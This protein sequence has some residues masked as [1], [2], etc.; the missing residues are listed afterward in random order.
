M[1]V[2][3]RSLEHHH[4]LNI[5]RTT[6][7]ISK[8]HNSLGN[9]RD[10]ILPESWV[11]V[12]RNLAIINDLFYEI[13]GTPRRRHEGERETRER[14]YIHRFFGFVKREAVWGSRLIGARESLSHSHA[15]FDIHLVG[16][17]SYGVGRKGDKGQVAHHHLLH[18]HT[19]CSVRV[20]HAST[21]PAHSSTLRPQ[22]LPHQRHSF[23][24]RNFITH[25]YIGNRVVQPSATHFLQVLTIGTRAHHHLR[26]RWKTCLNGGNHL[27]INLPLRSN[28]FAHLGSKH[29]S[30]LALD[31]LGVEIISRCRIR[32][33][34][35]LGSCHHGA[36]RQSAPGRRR[37]VAASLLFYE[38]KN[39]ARG[40]TLGTA[41]CFCRLRARDHR[42]CRHV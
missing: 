1:H 14:L 23:R 17:A 6:A 5:L 40:R 20:L 27:I 25:I 22:A 8:G 36:K 11:G 10:N 12:Q 33:P 21:T 39:L 34:T 24:Q 4:T 32:G 28:H 30:S 15:H 38:R 37:E 26:R 16:V 29:I 19:H 41:R 7:C 2:S 13:K 9:T 18:Q 3:S 42:R 31:S 35:A